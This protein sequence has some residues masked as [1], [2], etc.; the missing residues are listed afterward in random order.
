MATINLHML[1]NH[2]QIPFEYGQPHSRSASVSSSSSHSLSRPQSSH[3]AMRTNMGPSHEELYRA[4]MHLSQDHVRNSSNQSH[5]SAYSIAS[6]DLH[7]PAESP[8]NHN[9]SNPA[10][11][12]V[13]RP[14]HIRARAAASPYHRGDVDVYS[15][16][17]E[18]E[19]VSIFLGGPGAPG[20]SPDSYT[21]YSAPPGT[22]HSQEALNAAGAFDRM[23]IG[24]DQALEKLAANVRA[25]TTTSAA[26]RA[27]QIFV[28]A[29]CVVA[30]SLSLCSQSGWLT[31]SS[32]LFCL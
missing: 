15:S 20:G 13:L 31:Y 12:G 2:G 9:L 19:D 21:M 7:T 30:F 24:Q 26:D 11:K 23:T 8:P 5:S 4:G 6:T 28:Q 25:A 22:L 16:S 17:S 10:L 32:R 29:W 14:S 27:K 18:A 1:N 3:G